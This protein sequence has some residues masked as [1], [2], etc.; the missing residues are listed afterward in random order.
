M[1]TKLFYA[2]LIASLTVSAAFAQEGKKDK[3]RKGSEPPLTVVEVQDAPP[4]YAVPIPQKPANGSLFTESATN[5]NLL[6]DFR[7]RNLGDLVFIDVIETS[8]ANVTSGAQRSRDSGTLGGIVTAAGALPVP[9]AAVAG[10]VAGAL[11][12]RKFE[13]D[14][15]TQRNSRLRSRIAVRV[16][17]VMPNGD[18]RVEGIKQVRINKE[19]EQLAVTGIVR[20]NDIASDNSVP[21]VA[22]G[23]LRVEFNG[24]GVASADNAPGWLFRFF[25][26]ITPF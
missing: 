26:K 24:K 10:T 22:V 25:D 14:G 16:V 3:K 18:M 11:G 13:G 15:S 5:A 19:T 12:T 4:V 21:T 7:A 23:D 8:S 2:A 20:K 17:E 9:G 1:K 6:A